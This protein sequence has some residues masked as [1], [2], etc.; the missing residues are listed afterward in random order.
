MKNTRRVSLSFL[1]LLWVGGVILSLSEPL[2][3]VDEQA[4]L[5]VLGL[6]CPTNQSRVCKVV[7]PA[8]SPH[9][10]I[11]NEIA[12]LK[13]RGVRGIL[14][15]ASPK[16]INALRLSDALA[17]PGLVWVADPRKVGPILAANVTCRPLLVC[18][19]F[20]SAMIADRATNAVQSAVTLALTCSG[21]T[22][23]LRRLGNNPFKLLFSRSPYAPG[24]E[25]TKIVLACVT[26][27]DQRDPHKCNT[28]SGQKSAP[29]YALDI[30]QALLDQRYLMEFSVWARC[31]I[32][33]ITATLFG[34]AKS[35]RQRLLIL[36][37]LLA[38]LLPVGLVGKLHLPLG[39]IILLY[40]F[41]SVAE[42]LFVPTRLHDSIAS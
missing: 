7:V 34:S 13:S 26:R 4:A 18:T 29:D 36:V 31:A 20:G 9:E 6:L 21:D 11:A 38:T 5:M 40:L 8:K 33:G 1:S 15:F 10:T 16:D 14:L 42:P 39:S 19:E 28:P 35:G 30:C 17:V 23:T 37:A 2:T 32:A 41:V 22:R 27:D 12:L 25:A 3:F 24:R